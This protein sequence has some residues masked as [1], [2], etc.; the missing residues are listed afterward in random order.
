MFLVALFWNSSD[1]RGGFGLNGL[2]SRLLIGGEQH[3]SPLG[4]RGL[5]EGANL[6]EVLPCVPEVLVCQNKAVFLRV[7][8]VILLPEPLLRE[9]CYGQSDISDLLGSLHTDDVVV[10]AVKELAAEDYMIEGVLP[11][12]VTTTP[13]SRPE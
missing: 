13:P 8:G 4:S 3:M 7:D 9:P 10:F 5:E 12:I 1:S 11:C 6:L 2:L